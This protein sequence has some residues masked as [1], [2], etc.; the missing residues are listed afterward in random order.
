MVNNIKIL[1]FFDKKY[2]NKELILNK[3]EELNLDIFCIEHFPISVTI[4]SNENIK[5]ILKKYFN[6]K[7]KFIYNSKKPS[8]KILKKHRYYLTIDDVDKL[9]V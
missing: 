3:L 6:V 8:I 2:K 9:E 1:D 5:S 7:Y 4:Y